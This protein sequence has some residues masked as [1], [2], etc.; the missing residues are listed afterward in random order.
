MFP[1]FGEGGREGGGGGE[2]GLDAVASFTLPQLVGL[3]ILLSSS[4]SVTLEPSIFA[5]KAGYFC[6]EVRMFT[7]GVSPD[8]TELEKRH[9]VDLAVGCVMC[10]FSRISE[11]YCYP[12]NVAD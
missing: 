3:D 10:L 7:S 4:N 8:Y 1:F 2:R 5:S 12:V 6:N 11:L 9:V